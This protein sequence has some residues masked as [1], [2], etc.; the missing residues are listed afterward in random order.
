[1][2]TKKRSDLKGK[3]CDRRRQEGRQYV[4]VT[5]KNGTMVIPEVPDTCHL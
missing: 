1:M 5:G 4:S 2:G 3:M